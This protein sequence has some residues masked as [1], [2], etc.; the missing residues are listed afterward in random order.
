MTEIEYYICGKSDGQYVLVMPGFKSQESAQAEINRWFE[1]PQQY[2][3]KRFRKH[4]TRNEYGN[5]GDKSGNAE[6]IIDLYERDF[7]IFSAEK[8]KLWWNTDTD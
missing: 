1:N 6:P 8:D 4:D 5:F 2:M 3:R 7:K